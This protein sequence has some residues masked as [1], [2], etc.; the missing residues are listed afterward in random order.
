MLR[1]IREEIWIACSHLGSKAATLEFALRIP[2]R[3]DALTQTGVTQEASRL[4]AQRAE[5]QTL[6][7][8]HPLHQV[9]RHYL[10][11]LYCLKTSL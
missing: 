7:D 1:I 8:A 11:S 3:N 10:E 6:R 4:F 2:K 9:S 5:A